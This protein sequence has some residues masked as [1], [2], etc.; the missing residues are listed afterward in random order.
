MTEE[1]IKKPGAKKGNQNARKHGFYSNVLDEAQRAD[2]EKAI[3]V[4]GLDEE[5]AL[6]R[7]KIRALIQNDPENLR[8]IMQGINALTRLVT[9]KFNISKNDKQSIM[10]GVANVLKDVA[11]PI[12]IGIGSILK[13]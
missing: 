11:F 4:E 10:K 7:V 12:G 3:T 13:K 8:L 9:T 5:I 2:F 6:L 1:I